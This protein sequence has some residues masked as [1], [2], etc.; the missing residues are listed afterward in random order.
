[1]TAPCDLPGG[2][3]SLGTMA[4]QSHE[5][6]DTPQ[7]EYVP[8]GFHTRLRQ[9]L[10]ARGEKQYAFFRRFDCAPH[11]LMLVVTQQARLKPALKDALR[12]ALG[13]RAWDYVW[14]TE[15]VLNPAWCQ[16]PAEQ[17]AA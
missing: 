12:T 16:R 11:H 13:D 17:G 7:G 15:P 1:M 9:V 3:H 2:V 4:S 6:R 5:D 10:L 8:E 14:G